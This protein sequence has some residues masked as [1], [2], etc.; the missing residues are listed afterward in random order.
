MLSFKFSYNCF[1][2]R[3]FHRFPILISISFII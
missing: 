1:N 3:I 2:I